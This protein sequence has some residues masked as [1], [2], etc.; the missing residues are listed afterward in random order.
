MEEEGFGPENSILSSQ[1]A[2]SPECGGVRCAVDQILFWD[3]EGMQSFR[4]HF[5]IFVIQASA[6]QPN[7]LL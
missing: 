5:E 1:K 4:F 3:A 7:R 6:G 2:E